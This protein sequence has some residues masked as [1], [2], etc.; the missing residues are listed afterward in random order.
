M[1]PGKHLHTKHSIAQLLDTNK[2]Y[3]S[4]HSSYST[5]FKKKFHTLAYNSK[6]FC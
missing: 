3:P 6:V 2:R 1:I 5:L 4:R